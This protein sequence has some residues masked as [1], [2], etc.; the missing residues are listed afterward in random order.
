MFLEQCPGMF[1]AFFI[2][3]KE[4]QTAVCADFLVSNAKNGLNSTKLMCKKTHDVEIFKEPLVC[5]NDVPSKYLT[6]KV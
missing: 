1:L 6:V 5:Q 2:N 3:K 4:C